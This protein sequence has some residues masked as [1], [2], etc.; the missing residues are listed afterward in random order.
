MCKPIHT[1]PRSRCLR[2]RCKSGEIACAPGSDPRSVGR[3]YGRHPRA[4]PAG[5]WCAAT[6]ATSRWAGDPHRPGRG[7]AGRRTARPR[8]PGC[9]RTGPVEHEP[10]GAGAPRRVAGGEGAG[11]GEASGRS[12]RHAQT[13]RCRRPRPARRRRSPPSTGRASRGRTGMRFDVP[14][15][16]PH[17]TRAN[18]PRRYRSQASRYIVKTY[19]I[20]YSSEAL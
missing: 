16:L 4:A 6:R 17:Q 7:F 5:C 20:A 18:Q 3:G 2:R 8:A 13:F 15:D 11:T 19:A 12:P 1:T 9:S 14:P 10:R